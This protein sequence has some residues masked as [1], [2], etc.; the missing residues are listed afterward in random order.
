MRSRRARSRRGAGFLTWIALTLLVVLGVV[1]WSQQKAT[2]E[3]TLLVSRSMAGELG[4]SL[5]QSALEE[6]AHRIRSGANDPASPLFDLL[7]EPVKAPA[8]G[9]V[10]LTPHVKLEHSFKL[11]EKAPFKSYSFSGPQVEVVY[12]RQFDDLPYERTGLIHSWTNV[13]GEAGISDAVVRE[14]HAYH[15][16]RTVLI[17]TPRPFD[18]M[19][20]YLGRASALTDLHAANEH[21]AKLIAQYT[22]VYSAL[23]AAHDASQGPT[24]D[25]YAQMIMQATPP[26]KL[27]ESAPPLPEDPDAHV[28]AIWLQGQGFALEA[29][30]IAKRLAPMVGEGERRAKEVENASRA[31]IASPASEPAQE[32]MREATS[33]TL[34]L[35]LGEML[36]IWGFT[37]AFTFVAR[38]DPEWD[39]WER[40]GTER[41]SY[42]YFRR[43]AF[44]VLPEDPAWGEQGLAQPQWELL[45][46]K[47][48]TPT[49]QQMELNGVV[50]VDNQTAPLTLTGD[51]HGKLVVMATRGGLVLKDLNPDPDPGDSLVVVAAGGPIEISGK[52]NASVVATPLID[53]AGHQS[54]PRVTVRPGATIRGG[55]FVPG[56]VAGADWNGVVEHDDRYYGG[57][58]GSW[59]DHYYVGIA[60]RASFRQVMRK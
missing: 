13:V 46:K 52:V 10:S 56:G 16:L 12:Q 39:L 37:R 50:V 14:V 54:L 38:S 15:E 2:G 30:D 27:V 4:L 40:R 53:E 58:D 29:M 60:P 24:R 48:A 5:G 42:E 20:I 41:L 28:T 1:A 59:G 55:L 26:A 35:L 7:R 19:P 23:V 43:K 9:Q 44:W 45:L 57:P 18:E 31:A 11:L 34:T 49:G 25:L 6:V 17:T 36:R 32:A 8:T 51:L 33:E 22:R 21:R 3:A 47:V